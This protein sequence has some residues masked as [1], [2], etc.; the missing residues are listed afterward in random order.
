MCVLATQFLCGHSYLE[1]NNIVLLQSLED[2]LPSSL[3][4]G[5]IL[6]SAKDV[7]GDRARPKGGGRG[8]EGG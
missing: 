7:G 6:V 5:K 8:E 3:V 2:G 4:G 1:S